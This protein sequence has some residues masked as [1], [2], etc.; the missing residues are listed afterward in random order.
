MAVQSCTIQVFTVKVCGNFIVRPNADSNQLSLTAIIVHKDDREVGKLRM[1]M[2]EISKVK[3]EARKE[4]GLE[5][6]YN[7]APIIG[8][9]RR[10][11]GHC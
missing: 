2:T 7:V 3:L 9:R 6:V 1:E 11:L 5:I 4:Y 10:G 8:D